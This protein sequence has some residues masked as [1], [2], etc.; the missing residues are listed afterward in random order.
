MPGQIS[1]QH[2]RTHSCEQTSG[3]K[4]DSCFRLLMPN[5]KLPANVN[6]LTGFVSIIRF[7]DSRHKVNLYYVLN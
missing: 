5:S 7:I 4:F 1:L 6:N 3:M 2:G